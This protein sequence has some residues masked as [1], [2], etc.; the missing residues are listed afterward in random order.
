MKKKYCCAE[1]NIWKWLTWENRYYLIFSRKE[2]KIIFTLLIIQKS[3]RATN[4]VL[5]IF[6][7]NSGNFLKAETIFFVFLAS[8]IGSIYKNQ[9]SNNLSK[10]TWLSS[11]SG[12]F[13]TS[14]DAINQLSHETAS[15]ESELRLS[16][17]EKIKAWWFHQLS[18]VWKK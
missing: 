15:K 18:K 7:S 8:Y 13:L 4:C 12:E 17:E 6:L 1:A 3:Y 2:F 5:I 11:G 9:L 14:K 10:K 16:W